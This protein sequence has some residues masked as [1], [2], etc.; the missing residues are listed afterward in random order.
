MGKENIG[1]TE[2]EKDAKIARLEAQLESVKNGD[3]EPTIKVTVFERNGKEYAVASFDHLGTR[4]FNLGIGKMKAVIYASKQDGGLQ[5]ILDK[6]ES[7][8][9]TLKK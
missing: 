8:Q 7:K 3:Y 6:L 9:A 5:G 4:P 1:M 2:A